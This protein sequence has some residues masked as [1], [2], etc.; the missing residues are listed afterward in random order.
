[1]LTFKP[2]KSVQ[3]VKNWAEIF[4]TDPVLKFGFLIWLLFMVLQFGF[5]FLNF[6]PL[7]Q[8]VPLFYS[9]AWGVDR[10]TTKNYLWIL[11]LGILA[12][13]FFNFSFGLS[14]HKN[15]PFLSRMLIGI[16]NVICILAFLSLF[17]II[18]ILQ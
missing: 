9:R 3:T 13:S 2:S 15:N 1:M 8:I 4:K 5:L 7:P 12:F 14:F 16:A 17:N 10:L 11:P 6:S 18:N